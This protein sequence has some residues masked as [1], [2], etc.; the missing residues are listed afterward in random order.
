MRT[1]RRLQKEAGECERRLEASK[2]GYSECLQKQRSALADVE[3]A[4]LAKQSLCSQLVRILA[5]TEDEKFSKMLSL[6][7]PHSSPEKT[8]SSE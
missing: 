3:D 8:H 2:Q 5:M 7:S 6:S 1:V 4:A